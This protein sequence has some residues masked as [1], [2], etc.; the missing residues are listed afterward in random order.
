MSRQVDIFRQ[1]IVQPLNIHNF[2]VDI[3]ELG[4]YGLTIQSTQFPSERTRVVNLA[5][6]GE[7]IQYPTV[8]ETSHEWTFT[9][10]ENES[11]RARE[12]LEGMRRRYWDQEAGTLNLSLNNPYERIRIYARDL[13]R[14]IVFSTQ[15]HWAWVLGRQDVSL[16]QNAPTTPWNWQYAFRYDYL[17]DSK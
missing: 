10:P 1:Q 15:L 4:E 5:V 11:G 3:P 13:N 9:I 7:Q 17:V 14:R 8:P 2:L 6:S 16:D 12:I